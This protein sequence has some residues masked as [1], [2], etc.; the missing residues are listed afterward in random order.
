MMHRDALI[1]DFGSQFLGHAFRIDNEIVCVVPE[2]AQ[3]SQT[4]AA[5][6]R[7]LVRGLGGTCGECRD[8]PLGQAG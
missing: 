2:H 1:V 4:A 8:C 6:M 5:A 3:T 7:E